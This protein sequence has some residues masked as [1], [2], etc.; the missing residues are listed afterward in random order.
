MGVTQGQLR[1]TDPGPV[2]RYR[3]GPLDLG[4]VIV[5]ALWRG[6]PASHRASSSSMERGQSPF[7]EPGQGAVG[8]YATSRLTVRAIIG[9]VPLV[10]D[11]L[12]GIATHRARSSEL[13]VDCELVAEGG[14]LTS[15]RESIRESPAEDFDPM[16]QRFAN[17]TVKA[18][19]LIIIKTAGQ[20]DWREA[21]GMENLVAV[22]VADA[23]E[24]SRIG[25]RPLERVILHDETVAKNAQIDLKNFDSATVV[26]G[27]HRLA[28]NQMHA[29]ALLSSGFG[30]QERADRE[31]ESRQRQPGG[32]KGVRPVDPAEPARDHQMN[33]QKQR[34]HEF[35]ND[36]FAQAPQSHDGSAFNLTQRRF[37]RPQDEWT[38]Q[39]HPMQSA[40]DDP[41]P[42]RLDVCQHVWKFRHEPL[43]LTLFATI[44]HPSRSLL[45][46]LRP[47]R[48]Y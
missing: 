13:A 24:K 43:T 1:G 20:H 40:T 6:L 3:Q 44:R 23:A 38:D 33:D 11:P 42:Q 17:G 9:L 27:Q 5:P 21:C 14:D 31:I 16:V 28:A 45:A 15:A 41:W 37:H 35:Q 7:Q 10:A 46:H 4:G 34:V 25:Q 18:I 39:P 30:Q 47:G 29:G 22:G 32:H 36:T 26:L 48:I 19:D 2:L 12:N 8:Q